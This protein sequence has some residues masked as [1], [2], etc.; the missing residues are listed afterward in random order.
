MSD[1]EIS[2]VR[3]TALMRTKWFQLR[4]D[5]L[6]I[7]GG[8]T[9]DHFVL[10]LPPAC[11]VVALNE[12]REVLLIRQYR[13]ALGGYFWEI[14]GGAVQEKESPEQCARRELLEET[15]YEVSTLS[16]LL[17]NYHELCGIARAS[18][19]IFMGTGLVLRRAGLGEDELITE[20]KMFSLQEATRMIR[21]GLII[22]AFSIV[23]I[24]T[25]S[26]P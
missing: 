16:P 20:Q 25:A 26:S 11:A 8:K 15:G 19:T 13:H 2:V 24:M 12:N 18:M 3:S 22:S 1:Q 7:S 23:G 9:L 5:R 21:D 6:Q 10:E 14:P 17:T 4:R